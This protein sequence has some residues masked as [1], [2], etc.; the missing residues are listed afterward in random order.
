MTSRIAQIG[1]K[2]DKKMTAKIVSQDSPAGKISHRRYIFGRGLGKLHR[3]CRSSAC[4][5][6]LT[7][8]T[9]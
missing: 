6:M 5:F 1:A 8:N 2:K 9:F 3:A 7:D 4:S